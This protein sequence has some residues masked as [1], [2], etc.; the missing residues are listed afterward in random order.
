MRKETRPV[1]CGNLY[2]GGQHPISVQSMT[3][4]DP[5]KIE[6]S[7]SQILRLQ[8]AN[9]DIVRVAVPSMESAYSLHKIIDKISI[10]LVADIHFDYRI[11][12][13]AIHQGVDG[14][15]LNPGN[16]GS[17]ER[18]RE[19]VKAASEKKIPI[20]IGV[21]AGSL[22]KEL[23]KKYH[24]PTAEAMVESAMGHVRILEE[25]GFQ[26]IVISLKASDVVM[27]V[28]AYELISEITNYPLH[29]G[30]TEAGTIWSGTIKSAIGIGS[31]LLK[32]IGDTIRVSLTG[33]PVEEVKVGRQILKSLGIVQNEITIISCPTCGRCQVDLIKLANEAEKRIGNI[34]KPIKLAIMGCAVNGPGEAKEA[35]IGIAGG[36]DSV[37][38]F[39]KGQIIKKIPE[40][41]A[42]EVLI[43][44]I[45]E[46]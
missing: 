35:D 11:A 5:I 3:T 46:L 14:L 32:G 16:I 40:D 17:K 39:K 9:C 28:K 34:K 13:E 44:E 29:V 8:E 42:L 6:E 21:N 31:L 30:I 15:R 41:Q 20:R 18:V 36:K 22:E 19:V 25:L 37:L 1:K 12:L 4:T 43:K 24:H 10:P 26:D 33:D 2:V 7:I 23:L 27:T 45:E 38:L